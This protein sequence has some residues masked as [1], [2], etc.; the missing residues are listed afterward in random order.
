M[1]NLPE[2]IY[3]WELDNPEHFSACDNQQEGLECICFEIEMAKKEEDAES[4][5]ET[6]RGN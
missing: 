1:N 6:E 2:G 3:S 4:Q 5:M